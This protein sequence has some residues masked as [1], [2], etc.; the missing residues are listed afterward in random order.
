[1]NWIDALSK[2]ERSALRAQRQPDWTAPML[3][4]LTREHFSD[5]SWIYERKLDGQRLLAFRSGDEVRLMSRNKKPNGP[6]YPEIRDAL[7]TF[8]SDDFVIDGEVVAIDDSVSSFSKL[9]PRMQIDDEEAARASGVSVY[10]YVF[11]LLH[12]DGYD[13]T[14]LPLR[15][16]K[17][18]LRKVFDFADPVRY[19]T[20]RN[21]QGEA[22]LKEACE[23][24]WEGLIAKHSSA[25]YK[26]GRS[27][28]WLK[29][30]CSN[31][32]EFVIGGYTDPQGSRIGFGA[33]LIG[34]YRAGELYYAGKVG[35]GYDDAT[36]VQLHA[37]LSSIER[38]TP[39][40]ADGDLPSKGVHW[41]APK[42]V[43]QV[44]FTEWTRDGKLRHP[45]YLGLRDDKPPEAVQ[46]EEP[47]SSAV[48]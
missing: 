35:T 29:F 22:Y 17:S 25:S 26:H 42:L 10:Y 1:M 6:R 19:T 34:Y 40:F 8:S 47:Q 24:G 12:L 3:A 15:T 18:I 38:K 2:A 31:N 11:D 20:H 30:K 45:R 16:R 36:L 44:G 7:K 9:Q 37:R 48:S 32:Q 43:A 13:V 39:P 41:V 28:D 23:K 27:R 4:T 14:Q 5:S 46:R 21:E 33:L